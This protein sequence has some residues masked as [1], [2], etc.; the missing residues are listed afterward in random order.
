[1]KNLPSHFLTRIIWLI[2]GVGIGAVSLV[3]GIHTNMLGTSLLGMG[4]ALF[5]VCWFMQPLLFKTPISALAAT[6]QRTTIGSKKLYLVISF[7]AMA[8]LTVGMVLRYAF[9]S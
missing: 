2:F 7:S 6:V 8:C 1:M 3:D 5:G 4:M 9:Q